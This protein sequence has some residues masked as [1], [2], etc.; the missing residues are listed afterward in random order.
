MGLSRDTFY[1]YKSAHAEGGI[2][3]FFYRNRR[4]P[5]LKNRSDPDIEPIVVKYALE[6]PTHGQTRTSNELRKVETFVSSSGPR[7]IWLRHNLACF[8]NRLKALSDRVAAEQLILTQAQVAAMDRK[9]FDDE[10]PGE[11][12]YIVITPY[13][14]RILCTVDIHAP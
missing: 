12:K 14:T 8:K 4:S 1:R 11:I 13:I 3:T 6:E 10:A 9:K 2:E 5:N 7:S